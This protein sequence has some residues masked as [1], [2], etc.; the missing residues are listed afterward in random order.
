MTLSLTITGQSDSK[1][2]LAWRDD[3]QSFSPAPY[4]VGQNIVLDASK[5]IRDVLTRISTHYRTSD[6]PSYAAFL[7]ELSQRGIELYESLFLPIESGQSD[8]DEVKDYIAD[9]SAREALTIYSDASAHVPWGF[10]FPGPEAIRSEQAAGSIVD[11]KDF[12]S[13]R[14]CIAT[15]F[16]KTS[17]LKDEVRSRTNFRVLYVLHKDAF[18]KAR[19]QLAPPDQLCLDRLIA[20]DAANAV[21][22]NSARDKWRAI[23]ENDSIIYIFG[24]SN[25]Q[26]IALS[27]GDEPHHRLSAGAFRSSFKKKGT[28]SATICFTNGCWTAAGH[29]DQSFLTATALPGFHGFIGSEA[30]VSNE[31]ATRYG[32]EFMRDICDRG[33]SI[34]ETFDHLRQELFPLSLLY[35][36]FAHGKFRIEPRAPAASQSN[37]A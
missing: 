37:A 24:H 32:L 16:S 1:L 10:V 30:E 31:F 14:F 7:P 23:A 5:Q 12:W 19:S 18:Q 27:D 22:W 4:C 28:G 9:L 25:G 35:S 6:A 11:F 2:K 21:D 29:K 34:Q 15:R 17:H 13:S 8:A 20:Q 33:C 3:E 36:C 26:E